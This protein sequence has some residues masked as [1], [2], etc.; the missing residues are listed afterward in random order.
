MIP[1]LE[2]YIKKRYEELPEDKRPK[3]FFGHM[4]FFSMMEKEYMTVE[5]TQKRYADDVTLQ[6]LVRLRVDNENLQQQ[7]L[8]L[9]GDRDMYIEEIKELQQTL[10]DKNELIQY[11]EGHIEELKKHV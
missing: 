2:Q 4:A 9:A 5:E 11:L 8:M 10:R 6:E 3:G 1:R 7:V